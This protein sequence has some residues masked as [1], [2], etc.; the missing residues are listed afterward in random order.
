MR[1]AIRNSYDPPAFDTVDAAIFC[2]VFRAS[3]TLLAVVSQ[4]PARLVSANDLPTV[5]QYQKDGYVLLSEV[6]DGGLDNSPTQVLAQGL[7]GRNVV[8]KSSNMTNAIFHHP[9]AQR[10]LIGGFVNA[11][12]LIAYV[13][14][15]G[16]RSVELIAA[17][18]FDRKTEALE[19]VCCVRMLKAMLEGE[20]VEAIPGLPDIHAKLARKRQTRTDLHDHYWHDTELALRLNALPVLA[21]VRR[22]DGATMEVF[23]IKD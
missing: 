8:H 17:S 1:L 2:D 14:A 4:K 18:H 16:F 3:T 21:E 19:D 12:R 7:G 6:F 20:P 9:G 13:R 5:R 10:F 22:L 15:G 23:D 11:A